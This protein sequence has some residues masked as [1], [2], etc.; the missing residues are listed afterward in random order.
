MKITWHGE[1]CFTIEHQKVKVVTDPFDPE[2]VGLNLP[3]LQADYVTVSR[4][5][6][7]ISNNVKAVSGKP[8]VFDWPGEYESNDIVF[9][10]LTAYN[11]SK[12]D[13]EEDTG[14]TTLFII[15]FEDMTIAHL[16]GLGHRIP[17]RMLEKIGD[18]DILLIPVGGK[19]GI[20]AKKAEE[21]VSQIE[22]SV[23]IPMHYA[24]EGM[25]EKLASVSDFL[26][27]VGASETEPVKEF[28][29]NKS[30]LDKEKTETVI[31]ERQA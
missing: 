26:K 6:D 10:G 27:E 18:V 7:K 20:N 23:A 19:G 12:E 14:E 2:A 8:R 25:K 4:E 22:P 21:I 28:S 31:L 5:E 9:Q 15:R 13:G 11:F 16:G 1:N 30:D 29:P 24:Q 3:K 17:S